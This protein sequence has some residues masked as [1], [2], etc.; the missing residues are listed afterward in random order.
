MLNKEE[1]DYDAE[2]KKFIIKPT[3]PQIAI[4][5]VL[6]LR[7]EVYKTWKKNV[8]MNKAAGIKV[9]K[10]FVE[11][12]EDTLA[13]NNPD[14]S[15]T[16][17]TTISV[18]RPGAVAQAFLGTE[19]ETENGTATEIEIET[20]TENERGTRTENLNND[21]IE[22]LNETSNEHLNEHQSENAN[23]NVNNSDSSEEDDQHEFH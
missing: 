16:L 6:T 3:I 9:I 22:E 15:S 12:M 10:E 1:I 19:T 7:K 5:Y 4:L 18:N 17:R 11:S 20:E 13:Q 23:A 8:E 21:T 14:T 2:V